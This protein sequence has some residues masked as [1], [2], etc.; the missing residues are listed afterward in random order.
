MNGIMTDPRRQA[1][2]YVVEATNQEKT[3]LW[4][5][6]SC[7][8]A[9]HMYG[10]PEHERVPW[11]QVRDGWAHQVGELA[12]FPVVIDISF[13]IIYGELVM[14]YNGCSRVVDHEM[15][16]EWLVSNVPAYLNNHTN[17]TNF[18]HCMSTMRSK[19]QEKR[20]LGDK[21]VHRWLFKNGRIECDSCPATKMAVERK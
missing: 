2:V 4:C 18:G 8:A 17:S 7:E 6:W 1:A 19:F 15:L 16:R 13:A 12:G 3:M 21:H 10:S 20:G 9:D 11:E 5:E 14:F